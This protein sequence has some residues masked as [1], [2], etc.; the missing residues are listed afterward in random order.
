VKEGFCLEHHKQYLLDDAL[1]KLESIKFEKKILSIACEVKEDECF[2]NNTKEKHCKN[3][4]A[5]CP[6]GDKCNRKAT[7]GGF[8]KAH[9]YTACVGGE[10]CE[11]PDCF[12]CDAF[13][14]QNTDFL[15]NIC[16]RFGKNIVTDES[17][18]RYL[19]TQHFKMYTNSNGTTPKLVLKSV[20]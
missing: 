4:V 19:C 13:C 18:K 10:K 14:S 15:S 20:P 11:G 16:R 9:Y 2:T 6:N 17:G 7:N 12:P 5:I 8:C 1:A 3:C